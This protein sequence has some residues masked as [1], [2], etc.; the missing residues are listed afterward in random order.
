MGSR[1]NHD[2][3]GYWDDFD[4]PWYNPDPDVLR[5]ARQPFSSTHGRYV[6]MS[7]LQKYLLRH[8]IT[9][10]TYP[11]QATTRASLD[12]STRLLRPARVST[13]SGTVPRTLPSHALR[14]APSGLRPL[15]PLRLQREKKTSIAVTSSQVVHGMGRTQGQL[16]L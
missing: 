1:R 3:D 4:P 5:R 6:L 15:R 16:R 12:R 13:D 7:P 10:L 14:T 2:P 11:S 8:L 9:K